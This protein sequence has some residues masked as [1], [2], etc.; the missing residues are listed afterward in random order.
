MYKS[1]VLWFYVSMRIVASET[2]MFLSDVNIC[3]K[4][5]IRK[6]LKRKSRKNRAG[7]A[8]YLYRGRRQSLGGGIGGLPPRLYL[9]GAV[10][11]SL[12]Q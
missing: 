6:S 11:A 2:V 10:S 4:K 8:R 5:N 7:G 1:F 9:R 12:L 3:K